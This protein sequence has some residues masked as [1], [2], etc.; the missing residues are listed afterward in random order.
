MKQGEREKKRMMVFCAVFFS[1][2]FSP[3]VSFSFT[4]H[5]VEEMKNEVEGLRRE[6][7]KREKEREGRREKERER[8]ELLHDVKWCFEIGNR[9]F[10]KS[11]FLCNCWW[12]YFNVSFLLPLSSSFFLLVSFPFLSFLLSRFLP[13]PLPTRFLFQH[14]RNWKET[15]PS[16]RVSSFFSSVV[17]TCLHHLFILSLL[18]SSIFLSLFFSQFY[19]RSKR[20]KN[21]E[22]EKER[23]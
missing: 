9:V 10:F 5:D 22:K 1:L 14:I 21:R 16:E 17:L 13:F 20:E 11:S 15:F 6:S 19:F 12:C 7:K 4:E 18:Y 8:G 2:N 23:R 3:P